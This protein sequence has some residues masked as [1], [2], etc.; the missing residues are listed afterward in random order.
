MARRVHAEARTP[1]QAVALRGRAPSCGRPRST[2]LTL[3]S[4]VGWPRVAH[5][6]YVR[7]DNIYTAFLMNLRVGPAGDHIDRLT[8]GGLAVPPPLVTLTRP[9]GRGGSPGPPQGGRRRA[10]PV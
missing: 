4:T 10:G 5:C 2:P 7:F 6:S 1:F 3:P 8:P 9:G